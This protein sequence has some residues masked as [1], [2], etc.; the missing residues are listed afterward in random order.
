VH[1][2]SVAASLGPDGILDV[3]DVQPEMLSHLMRRAA[4]A[5]ITNI[6]AT[7]GDARTLPFPDGIFDAAYLISVLGEIPDQDAALRELRR[8]MKP[9]GRLVIGEFFIDPDFISAAELQHRTSRAGFTPGRKSGPRL[10]YF[11]RFE[12][13]RQ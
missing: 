2:L 12:M 10:A 6:V 8:V 13:P 1:A 9:N 4:T 3:F 11:A 7:H 5:G